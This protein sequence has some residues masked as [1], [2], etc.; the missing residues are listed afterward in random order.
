M[1]RAWYVNS[2]LVIIPKIKF[3]GIWLINKKVLGKFKD[4][5]HGQKVEVFNGIKSKLCA[6]EVYKNGKGARKAKS[7][8]TN[9][10]QKEI[11]FEDFR[12]FTNQTFY[13]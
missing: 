3:F 10:I 5:L 6:C 13:L 4:E 11:C 9:V 2:I 8:K 12:K 1:S 7:I